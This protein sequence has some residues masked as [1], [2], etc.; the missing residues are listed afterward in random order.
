MA[1]AAARTKTAQ[2]P[3]RRGPDPAGRVDLLVINLLERAVQLYG[4]VALRGV[5]GTCKPRIDR[6]LRQHLGHIRVY[7]GRAP[8]PGG[9]HAR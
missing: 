9:G 6:A 4:D 1:R 3:K 5:Y 7:M 8:R 2:T